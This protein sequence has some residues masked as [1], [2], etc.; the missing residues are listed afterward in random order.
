MNQ[1]QEQATNDKSVDMQHVAVAVRV[2]RKQLNQA[3]S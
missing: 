3:A 1:Q 2:K